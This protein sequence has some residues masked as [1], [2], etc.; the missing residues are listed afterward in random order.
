[1]NSTPKPKR[2]QL[3]INDGDTDMPNDSEASIEFSVSEEAKEFAI[4]PR[5]DQFATPEQSQPQSDED[6]DEHLVVSE[7]CLKYSK[8]NNNKTDN[9]ERIKI[10]SNLT[11][12]SNNNHILQLSINGMQM[13]CSYSVIQSKLKSPVEALKL[14]PSSIHPYKIKV[15]L[16]AK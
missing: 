1:M 16:N 13:D 14:L 4:R 2:E 15:I 10:Y 11:I 12:K 8:T 5:Q 9:K 7:A 6:V 3:G